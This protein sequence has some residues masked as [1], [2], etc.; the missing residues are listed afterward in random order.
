MNRRT[1]SQ[2]SYG[3]DRPEDLF[4]KLKSDATKITAVAHPHDIFNFLVTAAVLNEW[5]FKFFS[6]DSIVAQI[7][8]AKDKGDF[9]L[10][11]E[12]TSAWIID[13]KCLP[14]RHCDFRRHIM[15]AMSIIWDT[16]NASKHYHWVS[17][18]AVN[19]ISPEPVID[20]YYKYFFTSTA[21]DL[22]IDYDGEN[23]G[24]TQLNGIIMQFYEGLFKY[25]NG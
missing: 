22:Y 24:L 10:L 16:A 7:A 14:N 15:N 12:M 17:K 20:G 4:E 2:L 13:E 9:T 19:S 11:P 6:D 23:Y 18:S 3:I 8:H 21:P 25:I 1:M 5:T